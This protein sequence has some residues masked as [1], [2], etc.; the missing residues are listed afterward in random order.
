MSKRHTVKNVYFSN[1]IHFVLHQSKKH[2]RLMIVFSVSTSG[3]FCG[4]ECNNDDI[5]LWRCYC[6]NSCINRFS[7]FS[8][9]VIVYE[10]R[11]KAILELVDLLHRINKSRI[12][13]S[14]KGKLFLLIPRGRYPLCDHSPYII[15][16]DEF[17]PIDIQDL[18]RLPILP[19]TNIDP[20]SI[21]LSPYQPDYWPCYKDLPSWISALTRNAL[22]FFARNMLYPQLKN[23]LLESQESLISD[24]STIV[25]YN[26][27]EESFYYE[28]QKEIFRH[29]VSYKKT[30]FANRKQRTTYNLT[31]HGFFCEQDR[32]WFTDIRLD[33]LGRDLIA[34]WRPSV[35]PES[36]W[37][38]NEW[39]VIEDP[40]TQHPFF[41]LLLWEGHQVKILG[42]ECTIP[43]YNFHEIIDAMKIVILGNT[44]PQIYPDYENEKWVNVSNFRNGTGSIT[45]APLCKKYS[46]VENGEQKELCAEL[47]LKNDH[48]VIEFMKLFD[49]RG[50]TFRYPLHAGSIHIKPDSKKQWD[51]IEKVLNCAQKPRKLKLRQ[52]LWDGRC[53]RQFKT[54]ELI[55]FYS[56]SLVES[57]D[58]NRDCALYY[59]DA[60]S[61][62][63][64]SKFKRT[65]KVI[66]KD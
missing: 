17:I 61:K 34:D 28:W 44:A 3:F 9:I 6:N 59:L 27:H 14:L 57:F 64:S 32:A 2:E 56:K 39:S 63:Y 15:Q 29:C 62:K 50:S 24:N 7:K 60:L 52:I 38:K 37:K 1:R 12:K 47:T 16:D 19:Y 8:Q 21:P 55:Q 54:S 51:Y 10:R 35:I 43:P 42:L 25:H 26:G 48:Y 49:K 33:G 41:P 36:V 18:D 23:G 58:G 40:G 31:D 65:T 46:I 53:F 11:P 66:D 13:E 5:Q 20:N 45:L 30:S 4:S 22:T